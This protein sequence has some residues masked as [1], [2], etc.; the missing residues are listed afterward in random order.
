VRRRSVLGALIV[1]AV[2]ATGCVQVQAAD[3]GFVMGGNVVVREGDVARDDVVAVGGNVRIDGRATRDVVVVG[4]R[5]VING[6]AERN[7]SCVGGTLVLGPRA[8]VG[9]DVVVVGGRLERSDTARIGGEVV[10]VTFGPMQWMTPS[11]GGWWQYNPFAWILRTT[12]LFYWLLFAL[13]AVALVGDRVSST[14]HAISREP[15]RMGAIGLVALF[16]LFFAFLILLVMS[17]LIIGIPFLLALIILWFVAYIFGVVAVFQSVGSRV[18][19]LV[20]RPEASQIAIVLSGGLVMGILRYMPFFGWALWT[21]A[22]IVG[23]GAVFATRFGTGRP[24]LRRA[25]PPPPH[26]APPAPEPTPS[27]TSASAGSMQFDEPAPDSNNTGSFEQPAEG[28][29][30]SEGDDEMR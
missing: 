9:R 2:L 26:Y 17:F 4:G 28:E 25:V 6:E 13:V 11:W 3:S 1:V 20:G 19:R 5:L 14:S 30:G 22:A 7:V 23:V 27:E 10:N 12:Q 16:A 18:M 24:W 15:L 8:R 21:V 29:P